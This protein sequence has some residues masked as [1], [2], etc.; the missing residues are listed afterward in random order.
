MRSSRRGSAISGRMVV[1]WSEGCLRHRPRKEAQIGGSHLENFSISDVAPGGELIRINQDR[2][3]DNP[4]FV[5]SNTSGVVF[6]AS[7]VDLIGE[8]NALQ[9]AIDPV[10]REQNAGDG[11]LMVNRIY[12]KVGNV[13]EWVAVVSESG[14]VMSATARRAA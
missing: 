6:G 3:L 8:S 2:G 9:V 5:E 12:E 10:E 1:K 13:L 14:Q 11:A 7:A 4:W